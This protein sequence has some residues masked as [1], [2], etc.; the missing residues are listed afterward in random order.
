MN[1]PEKVPVLLDCGTSYTKVLY[2]KNGTRAIYPTRRIKEYI[3]GMRVIAATG[4]NASRFSLSVTNELLAL[5]KG[6]NDLMR[7]NPGAAV[8]D[9]GSRDIKYITINSENAV[10]IDWNTECG[11]F[12]GQLIELLTSYFGFD[13]SSI[14]PADKPLS[15]PCGILGMT[16]MFDLIAD[17]VD[18]EI[19]FARFM[20]GMADNIYRFCGEPETIYLSGG[21]CDNPLFIK[22]FSRSEVI[23]LGRFVLLDGLKK[24]LSE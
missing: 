18:P 10:S 4:H 11:A 1:T 6:T 8:V 20:R 15:L 21:L 22:S 19:A 13:V 9:C 5:A 17:D 14:H 16:R 24:N 23:P 2:T 7:A 12:C 3:G